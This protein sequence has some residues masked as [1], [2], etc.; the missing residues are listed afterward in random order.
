[1]RVHPVATTTPKLTTQHVLHHS[2]DF[3][4]AMPSFEAS[5]I[6]PPSQV[7][8]VVAEYIFSQIEE[9]LQ[10]VLD[11]PVHVLSRLFTRKGRNI[12]KSL[13]Y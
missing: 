4:N 9:T 7:G 5:S 11:G 10:A 2:S 12:G 13:N 1:M 6:R 8:Q 3:S